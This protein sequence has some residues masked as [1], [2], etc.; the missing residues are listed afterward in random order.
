MTQTIGKLLAAGE[1][2]L[3][4]AG[5]VDARL[6]ARLLLQ[7]CLGVNA[8]R[9]VAGGNEI[10]GPGDADRYNALLQRRAAS[11]P[12]SRII[13][14]REFYGLAFEVTPDVL[15]PRPD[16][17]LLVDLALKWAAGRKPEI[18]ILDLGAG[19]G[20]IGIAVLSGLPRA[21]CLAVDVSPSALAVAARNA[22]RHDV[23]DRMGFGQSDFLSGVAGLF[24]L[25]LS[26]PPY[27]RTGAIP[28]LDREVRCHDPLLALDGGE[29]GLSAY[30]AILSRAIDFLTHD[31]AVMLECG[32]GQA[33]AIAA[34]GVSFG[35]QRPAVYRDLAGIERVLV[36]AAD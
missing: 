9:I 19:S 1:A 10:V 26:N 21:S 27:I 20:A 16:T 3:L 28:G 29:D 14:T 4:A 34:L 2:R 7:A 30:R 33:P 22:A 18:R 25:V 32:E 31:G 35:W 8:A 24:D 15:D 23:A 17:E 11:E 13:G 12:V 5:I 6:D 36:F